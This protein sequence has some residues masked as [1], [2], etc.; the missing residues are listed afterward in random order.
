M[1]VN[2]TTHKSIFEKIKA[3]QVSEIN[4]PLCDAYAEQYF[5]FEDPTQPKTSP[6]KQKPYTQITFVSEKE[7]LTKQIKGIYMDVFVKYIPVGFKKN[8]KG[9]TIEFIV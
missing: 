8:D 9:I 4:L 3:G 6:I 1:N 7:Q 5:E 2:H